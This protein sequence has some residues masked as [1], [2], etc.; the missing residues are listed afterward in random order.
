MVEIVSIILVGIALGVVAGILPGLGTGGLMGIMF[1]LLMQMDPVH[2][3]L[4]FICILT[5]AQ[6][7]G[8]TIAILSGIPG[9][10]SAI[11]SSKWGFELAQKGYGK[12]I[13]YVTAK[14]SLLAGLV[15]FAI[16]LALIATS[17]Y[18]ASTLSVKYQALVITVALISITFI[19]ENRWHTNIALTGTGLALGVVGYSVNYQTYFLTGGFDSLRFGIPWLPVLVGLLAIPGT[20]K[21]FNIELELTAHSSKKKLSPQ[22]WAAVRGGTIGFIIGLVPGL[23]YILSSIVAAKF[24]E[25]INTAPEGIVVASESANNSGAVSVL[26]PLLILGVPITAAETVVFT[27]LTANATA[28]SIPTLV[29]N[30]WLIFGLS[31]VAINLILFI[32]AW[33]TSV[34]ICEFVFRYSKHFGYVAG[35]LAIGSIAWLGI[36]SSQ[37]ELYIAVL[38][39]AT[40]AGLK[41]KHIDWTP[42]IFAMML[43]EY[44]ESTVYKIQQL[45]F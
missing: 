45:F 42:L 22:T 25:K 12:D 40:L 9:D 4:F 16:F 5:S 21:L 7:F 29:L 1:V 38:A 34:K 43:Q 15:S 23:S 39:V 41:F 33:K 11:P 14:Y 2:V 19:S 20:M 18:S 44:V 26:L 13:L 10:P 8:S 36:Q 35:L 30:N 24:E 27:A 37:L 31:F 6:Y 17:M 28:S 3:L 32:L